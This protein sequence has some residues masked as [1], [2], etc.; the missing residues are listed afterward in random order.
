MPISIAG[1][2]LR[3]FGE[4]LSSRAGLRDQ[5]IVQSKCGIIRP[6]H[7]SPGMFDFSFEHIVESVEKSLRRLQTHYL[8]VLLLHRP[9]PLVEPIE[10]A[11]AFDLLHRTGRVRGSE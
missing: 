7:N 9:D 4:F 1:E 6:T 3:V 5:I 8:D 10:V 2:N 11:K